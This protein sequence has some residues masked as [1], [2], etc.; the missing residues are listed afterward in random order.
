MFVV[1]C[2]RRFAL[3]RASIRHLGGPE[4]SEPVVIDELLVA[5]VKA[6]RTLERVVKTIAVRPSPRGPDR[7]RE[8][9]GSCSVVGLCPFHIVRC[10]SF[11]MRVFRRGGC[12]ALCQEGWPDC[13]ICASEVPRTHSLMLMATVYR[14]LPFVVARRRNGHYGQHVVV[15]TVAV[16]ELTF[17][18]PSV[19]CCTFMKSSNASRRASLSC[20]RRSTPW[21][22]CRLSKWSS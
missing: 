8:V 17:A 22:K 9:C 13:I 16:C 12:Q 6:A 14:L 3:W 10:I 5:L 11:G 21:I 18:D 1:S 19:T 2:L 4:H 7:T 15:L 20:P